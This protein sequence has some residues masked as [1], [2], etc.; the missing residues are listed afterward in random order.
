MDDLAEVVR[1]AV[2]EALA[3][4]RER[5]APGWLT[6][7]QAAVYLGISVPKLEAWRLGG[8]GPPFTRLSRRLVRYSRAELDA[9]MRAH[10]AQRGEAGER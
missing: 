7:Q 9:W 8:G 6:P 1:A 3:D 4:V 2:R 5:P 10:E